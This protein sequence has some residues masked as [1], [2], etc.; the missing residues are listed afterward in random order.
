MTA[1]TWDALSDRIFETGVD[2]GVLY[3]PNVGGV[4]DTG[5]AWNGL[6]SVTESPSGAEATP[7]YADNIKYLNLI[8]VEQFEGTIEAFTYPSEF[9]ACDGSV[10]PE[11]GLRIGQQPR[12]SFGFSYRTKVGNAI[13]PNLGYKI[14]LVWGCMATPSEKAYNT[15]NDSPE[16]MTFSWDITTTPV[17]VT[18]YEPTSSMTID[19][20]VVD[21]TALATLESLLYGS[22]GVD[23]ALPTPDEVIALF[24]GTVTEATPLAP[25]YVPETEGVVIPTVTGVV[26]K[27]NGTTVTGTV[28]ITGPTV[29]KASPAAGYKFPAIIASEWYYTTTTLV[30]P[31]TPTYD[32]GTDLVTIPSTTGVVYKLDGTTVSSG[33]HAITADAVVTATPASGY[34]FPTSAVDVW[35]FTFA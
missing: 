30:T 29:V 3:L 1:L 32:S 8:S 10:T 9:A 25:S 19:S 34:A 28:T 6:V 4:Y 26:Y 35:H 20:T 5:F 12:S 7:Q 24:S 11:A 15:V 2:H 31:G 23:P 18:G 14:H 13:D 33:T 21:S 17:S 27:I 22:V 16:A